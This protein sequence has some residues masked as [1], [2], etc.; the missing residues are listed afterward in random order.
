M[1]KQEL[2]KQEQEAFSKYRQYDIKGNELLASFWYKKFKKY[3]KMKTLA[4]A[5]TKRQIK[6]NGITKLNYI[7]I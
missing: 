1:G 5:L 3:T 2:L 4:A 7:K 6:A